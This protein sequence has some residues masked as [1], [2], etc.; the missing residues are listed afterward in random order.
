MLVGNAK[1][2]CVKT[3]HLVSLSNSQNNTERSAFHM[4]NAL[5]K[6]NVHVKN[7]NSALIACSDNLV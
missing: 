4:D 1:T 7:R 5:L 3:M 2:S 6:P